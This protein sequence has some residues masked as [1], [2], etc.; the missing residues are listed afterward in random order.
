MARIRTNL[1]VTLLFLAAL[2]LWPQTP[3][4][5]R[6][7]EDLNFVT[8][9]LPRRHA[10][11]F[12]QLKREDFDRAVRDLDSQI[13]SISDIQFYVRLTAL[14]AMAGDA[15]TSLALNG[16]AA[17]A[18]G[19]REFPLVFRWLD[20]GIFVTGAAADY[21]RALATQLVRVGEAPIEEVTRR[22]ETVI[23]H[24][25]SQWVR[26]S[27]QRYLAGQQILQG[28]G[29]V[30]GG[31]TSRLTFRTRAGEEF[32]LDV[33]T[34]AAPLVSAPAPGEGFLPEY[35]QRANENYWFS[36]SASRQLLYFR[37]NRCVEMPGRPFASFAAD[38]LRVLDTNPID[39]LVIDL[40]GN[41]G[42]DSGIVT[43]LFQGL[44]NR[45]PALLANPRLRLYGVIDK[46]TFSSGMLN[47]MDL[48]MPLP[49]EFAALFPGIDTTKLVRVIG[50]PTGG[51][52]EGYGEVLPFTL[53]SSRLL[54]QYSTRFFTRRDYIPDGPSFAPDIAVEVRSSDFFAR[55]DPV[56]AAILARSEGAPPAPSGD[57]IV[58]NG[59]SFRV[60][61][62]LAAGSFASAFGR[63]PEGVDEILVDGQAGRVVSAGTLQVNFVVPAPARA[64]R[65]TI[66]VRARGADVARGAATITAAGPGI[67]VL[68][69][70]DPAQPGAVLNQDS[71]INDRSNRA[72][73][74]S[75]LQIFA[76]GYGPLAKVFLGGEAAEVLFSGPI[77]QFPGLWQINA[78]LPDGASGQVPLFVTTENFASNGVTV[79]VQ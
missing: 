77:S 41:T 54:G 22:L 24:E 58:V 13:P 57:V 32:T 52:P 65:V 14:V 4:E 67:F 29:V 43:P 7:R 46:G 38:L 74:G 44:A 75:I 78:R 1:A 31:P 5:Q 69:A 61:Q 64:G 20:D 6:L 73:R 33:G 68:Q 11:F 10:N 35:L 56:L 2:P 60:A 70:A 49:P 66:V 3:R 72:P 8:T 18:L 47:A 19:F 9:E 26:F 62:G 53:P 63:F 71:T 55:H 34:N 25:N 21:S 12:F 39:T 23:S 40:R 76:T 42:G 45:L 28:L 59:A 79:W 17:A 50:E 36:Y 37:Y 30:P 27:A 48:K 51:K 16:S 15:H